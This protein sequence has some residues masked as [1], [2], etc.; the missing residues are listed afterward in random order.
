MDENRAVGVLE[1]RGGSADGG[2]D[3]FGDGLVVSVNP[4]DEYA[5]NAVRVDALAG[6]GHGD[7][8]G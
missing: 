4:D 7:V 3:V 2:S 6:D 5:R 8:S 1:V